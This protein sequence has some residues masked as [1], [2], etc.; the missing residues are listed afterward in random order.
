M[1]TSGSIIS[2]IKTQNS[3]K[4]RYITFIT[5]NRVCYSNKNPALVHC[6]YL[7]GSEVFT[8]QHE[9][10]KCPYGITCDNEGLIYVAG[11][12]SHNVHQ[13]SPTGELI[14]LIVSK[15]NEIKAIHYNCSTKK[16]LLTHSEKSVT[17]CEIK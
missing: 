5:N 11:F 12:C 4:Q 10:L 17:V 14:K 2:H 16:L 8:Y 15:E 7:D 13:I 3:S 1:D 9:D 6:I